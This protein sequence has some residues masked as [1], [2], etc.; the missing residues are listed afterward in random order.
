MDELSYQKR[1][2]AI[3]LLTAETQAEGLSTRE[4]NVGYSVRTCLQIERERERVGKRMEK[5]GE[6]RGGW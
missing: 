1:T 4:A 6:D 2:S 3:A 5:R